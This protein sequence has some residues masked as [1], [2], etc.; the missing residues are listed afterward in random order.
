MFTETLRA[1]GYY[2]LESDD[3]CSMLATAD[4]SIT[5]NLSSPG[6]SSPITII[7][8]TAVGGQINVNLPAPGSGVDGNILV[9]PTLQGSL[10]N[11]WLRYDWTGGA[12]FDDDPAATASFGIY[13]GNPVQIFIE[14][15]YQ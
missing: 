1:G 10:D 5:D 3:S 12:Q 2:S 6:A 8:A 13:Q 14:Q 7:N 15:T 11:R 4:L 9:T